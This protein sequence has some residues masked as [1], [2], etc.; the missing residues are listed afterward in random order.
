MR[1][2]CGAWSHPDCEREQCKRNVQRD[3]DWARMPDAKWQKELW[4]VFRTYGEWRAYLKKK[5]KA[6]GAA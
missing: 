4:G 6:K 5:S 3:L 2:S 1:C